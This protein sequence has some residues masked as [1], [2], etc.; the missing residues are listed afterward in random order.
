MGWKNGY[1]IWRDSSLSDLVPLLGEN[2]AIAYFGYEGFEKNLLV[3]VA[4]TSS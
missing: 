2:R 1:W 4:K 3:L